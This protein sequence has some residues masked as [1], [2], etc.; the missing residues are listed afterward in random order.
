MCIRDRAVHEQC[1]GYTSWPQAK[2]GIARLPMKPLLTRVVSAHVMG[3]A[4]MGA[5][6]ATGLTA[7]DGTLRGVDNVS[8]FDGS[9]FPTSIGANP[10]LSVYAVAARNASILTSRITG[11]PAPPLA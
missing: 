6:E 5:S 3:G 8:V 1:R 7:P 4:A 9:V 10:Q 11:K 2:E